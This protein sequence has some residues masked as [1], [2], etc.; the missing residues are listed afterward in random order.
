V[1]RGRAVVSLRDL[2]ITGDGGAE[3]FEQGAV[4]NAGT[5][6]LDH[7]QVYNATHFGI[8][9]VGTITVRQSTVRNT[10]PGTGAG[11][12]F[13]LGAIHNDGSAAVTQST[14]TANDGCGLYGV[15]ANVRGTMV[16]SRSSIYDNAPNCGGIQTEGG[17]TTVQLTTVSGADIFNTSDLIEKSVSS[18]VAVSQSTV[19][20]SKGA[21]IVNVGGSA[22]TTVKSTILENSSKDCDGSGVISRGYNISNVDPT[23]CLTAATDRSNTDPLLK[24]LAS[25]GGPTKT[26]ALQPTSPAI[27]AGFAGGTLTDQR[28]QR[29]IVDYPGVPTAAGGDNSDIGALELQSP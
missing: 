10:Q 5:L 6:S 29:R 15:L 7:I 20:G 25:N 1:V 28:G 17:T 21:N 27:D 26:F 24:P 2:S 8:Y 3:R 9:N 23:S 18:T 19:V 14:F 12:P 16:V 22:T 4:E 13:S 11:Y